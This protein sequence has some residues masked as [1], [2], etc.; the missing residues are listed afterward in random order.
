MKRFSTSTSTMYEPSSSFREAAAYLS[1]AS[2]LQQVST[3]TKLELYGLFKWL[4]VSPSPN[5]SRPSIFDMTGRAKWDA[6]K[7]T[8]ENYN[9]GAEGERRYLQIARDL[10]WTE[11]TISKPQVG[12]PEEDEIDWDEED[13]PTQSGGVRSGLGPSISVMLKDENDLLPETDTTIHDFAVS[14]DLNKLMTLLKNNPHLNLNQLD[15]N[16]YAPLHLASDRGNISVVKFLLT[17][18]ADPKVKDSDG[19]TAH[20]L[21]EVAGRVDIVQTLSQTSNPHPEPFR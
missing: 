3:A 13:V 15:E 4:T 10:G 8:G 16:G 12:A 14:G 7:S 11:G 18:G 17:K 1:S 20:D 21:A 19:M 2:S 5:T 9:D 6:W